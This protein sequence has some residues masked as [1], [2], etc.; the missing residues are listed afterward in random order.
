M[1]LNQVRNALESRDV[2]QMDDREE[3]GPGPSE[4]KRETAYPQ[5]RLMDSD[6]G[7]RLTHHWP[8]RSPMRPHPLIATFLGDI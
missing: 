5:V 3:I 2:V 7:R 4:A 1:N 8:L 6:H